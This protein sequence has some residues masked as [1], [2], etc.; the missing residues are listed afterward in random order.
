MIILIENILLRS[1]QSGLRPNY[2]CATAL[3]LMSDNWLYAVHSRQMRCRRITL[4]VLGNKLQD[5]ET[6]LNTE[7]NKLNDWC[8]T[9]KININVNKSK[10]ML[11]TTS[12]RQARMPNAGLTVHMDSKI[13][14]CSDTVKILGVH[15]N[16]PLDC[17]VQTHFYCLCLSKL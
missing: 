5:V 2:S 15:A 12:Q 13:I 11:V 16:N 1:I 14:P 17:M 9:D 3:T 8:V 6:E 7:L 10:C 4:H